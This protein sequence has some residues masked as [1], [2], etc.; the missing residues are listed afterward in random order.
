MILNVILACV[1]FL[2]VRN[3]GAGVW[4]AYWPRYY[5]HP[6][7]R[8]QSARLE[9]S[10]HGKNQNGMHVGCSAAVHYYV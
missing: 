7:P 5:I 3:P 4:T 8:G 6:A 10:M 1:I 9:I 2:E